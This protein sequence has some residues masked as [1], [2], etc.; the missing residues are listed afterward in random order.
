MLCLDTLE[1]VIKNMN[2]DLA[3]V[4]C[5]NHKAGKKSINTG[6]FIL[7][8]KL[9]NNNKSY[10]ELINKVKKLTGKE[11]YLDQPIINEWIKKRKD[12]KVK[13]L[14]YEYNQ[15]SK[16]LSY[17]KGKGIKVF[18]TTPKILHFTGN[19]ISKPWLSDDYKN[20]KNKKSTNKLQYSRA[21]N[22]WYSYEQ[23][24]LLLLK[25]K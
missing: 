16:D 11:Q 24:L 22:L 15:R 5:G 13:L 12:L 23:K 7:N 2:K 25:E 3:A 18:K 17:F 8:K 14:P 6:F 4:P 21:Y 1:N 10:N 9:I 20:K 19:G